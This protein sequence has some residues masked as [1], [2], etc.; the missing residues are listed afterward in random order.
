VT[1]LIVLSLDLV[2]TRTGVLPVEM[3]KTFF[4]VILSHLVDKSKDAKVIK[5]ITKVSIIP[6]D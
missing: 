1:E 6:T 4:G 5:A 3:R 2:K